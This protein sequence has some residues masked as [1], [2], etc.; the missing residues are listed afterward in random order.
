MTQIYCD[1]S[2]KKD[3]SGGYGA[4]IISPEGLKV[5]GGF[6]SNATCNNMELQ[7]VI[8]GLGYIGPYEVEI[9][10][11]SQYFCTG[12]KKNA[13]DWKK[14]F[15]SGKLIKNKDRWIRIFQLSE[16]RTINALWTRGH[17]DVTFNILADRVANFC[18]IFKEKINIHYQSVSE[19]LEAHESYLRPKD[20]Y[21]G[22]P[23]TPS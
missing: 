7:A 2:R 8:A 13:N 5:V 1:G 21:A 9:I 20:G 15:N 17:E 10:S 12:F 6:E 14:I 11:D 4:I 18:C 22:T 19:L 3:G 23:A 16:G